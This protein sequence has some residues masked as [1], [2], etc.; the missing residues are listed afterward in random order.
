[1]TN[2]RATI[3]GQVP[4][5][6]EEQAAHDAEII[7][8]SQLDFTESRAIEIRRMRNEALRASDWRAAT[9]LIMSLEWIAYRQALRDLP[10]KPGFPDSCI[11]NGRYVLP[12]P[13]EDTSVV[14]AYQP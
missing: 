13:P 4:Y 12:E 3:D 7:R 5:T 1:M 2:Y 6:P 9:D 8:I 11:E 14:S 10:N